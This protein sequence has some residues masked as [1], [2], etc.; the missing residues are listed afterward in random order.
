MGHG[1]MAAELGR[2]GGGM[3][4]LKT[5]IT[6][7]GGFLGSR[8]AELLLE[9]GHDVT[10]IARNVYPALEKAGAKSIACDLC[11]GPR[12]R[13]TIKDVDVVF[14]VA[15]KAG[16]WGPLASYRG[17][18]VDGTRNVI[19]A[20]RANGVGRLVY[21]S[22]PS[23]IGYAQEVENGSPE[24][25]Y[26]DRHESP[27]PETKAEAERMVREANGPELATVSL[28]PHLIIGPGDNNLM[29]RIVRR[30]A[31]GKLPIVG[32][33]SNRVDLT[34]VDNAAWAHIDA[35]HGLT[36]PTAKCAGKA[37]FISN[38]EPVVLWDWLNGL[39]RDLGLP[40]VRK[41][42]SLT[43]ARV[44]GTT[45]ELAWNTFHLD[46][47]PRLTRFLASALARSHWYDMK[48]AQEDFNYRVRVPMAEGTRRTADWLREHVIE[49]SPAGVERPADA[50][51]AHP[52]GP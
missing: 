27:Y 33:G 40:E 50:P 21:T 2:T 32:D 49:A 14:H 36:S 42:V 3:T 39:L 41:R 7:G 12:V 11:D 46:G 23:V 10:V 47:E 18:N 35:A 31:D 43:T 48:P 16:Y 24:L 45:L 19:D 20:C 26:A 13:E 25:P 8:L 5:L 30:A 15:A 51:T 9:E 17:V 34:Y 28:R 52:G 6:G 1:A 4:A 29:P 44:V 37:Y 22:T 38:G